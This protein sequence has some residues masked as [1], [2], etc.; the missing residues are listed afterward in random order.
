M[1]ARINESLEF[2]PLPESFDDDRRDLNILN[3][4]RNAL[5]EDLQVRGDY[6]RK[7]IMQ[8]FR[9]WDLLWPS[10][11]EADAT[12]LEELRDAYAQGRLLKSLTSRVNL[13][14][15]TRN[16]LDKRLGRMLIDLKRIGLEQ[17][18]LTRL[19]D[20]LR[21]VKRES[22]F[23]QEKPKGHTIEEW[24]LVARTADAIVKNPTGYTYNS[25]GTPFSDKTAKMNRAFFWLTVAGAIRPNETLSIKVDEIDKDGFTYYVTKGRDYPE[26][27][28]Q[29]MRDEIWQKVVPYLEVRSGHELLFPSSYDTHRKMAKVTM[30][31]AGL[32]P[33]NGRL[34]VHGFRHM[35]VTHSVENDYGTPEERQHMLG[36]TTIDAQR[37]YLRESG[38]Q[39][40]VDRVSVPWQ[41]AVVEEAGFTFEWDKKMGDGYYEAMLKGEVPV[42]PIEAIGS[43]KVVWDKQVLHL[44]EVKCFHDNHA[45]MPLIDENGE[46]VQWGIVEVRNFKPV[47][48]IVNRRS[49][50]WARPDLNRSP[51]VE[52][53]FAGYRA[54][55][56]DM[57]KSP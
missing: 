28:F 50:G 3:S 54:A 9:D 35:F 46:T 2:A 16:T 55:L 42:V 33:H 4:V 27:K 14:G 13:L 15:G 34:G 39:A 43:G 8:V 41:E 7:T 53:F 44:G 57:G 36:Q 26:Q 12:T 48:L 49:Y 19:S 25:S 6:A 30:L 38:K 47:R 17:V 31:E 37:S 22:G 10:F 5:N 32:N 20:S 29:P 45:M 21:Q 40:G 24:G 52:Q 23:K 11:V 1:K 51:D 18:H 56:D